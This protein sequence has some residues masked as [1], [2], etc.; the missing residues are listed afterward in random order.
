MWVILEKAA[1]QMEVPAGWLLGSQTEQ[2]QVHL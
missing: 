2:V 1:S